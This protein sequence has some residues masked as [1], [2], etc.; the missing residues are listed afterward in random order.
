MDGS[1][2]VK[3]EVKREK[4]ERERGINGRFWHV[5]SLEDKVLKIKCGKVNHPKFEK[6]FCTFADHYHYYTCPELGVG[7]A[8]LRRQPCN[9]TACDRTIRKP[10]EEDKE[11]EDQSRFVNPED[12]F[13]R[14]VFGNHNDWHIV[15]IHQVGKDEKEI[16]MDEAEALHDILH[17]VGSAVAESVDVG[18]IGAEG[19]SKWIL[20]CGVH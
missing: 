3:S 5:R 7:K 10:W 4:R 2:G 20:S 18:K 19:S 1:E 8:A 6:K 14:D 12:C 9:C 15:D 11:P 13:W 16:E 17:H